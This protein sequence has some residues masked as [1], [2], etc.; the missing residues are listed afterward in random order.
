MAGKWE[1]WGPNLGISGCKASDLASG[2]CNILNLPLKKIQVKVVTVGKF[3]GV[4][5]IFNFPWRSG[6][7]WQ[8]RVK[9]WTWVY[10]CPV[11][12][13]PLH[14]A[15]NVPCAGRVNLNFSTSALASDSSS[16]WPLFCKLNMFL[17]IWHTDGTQST[18]V[19][20]RNEWVNECMNQRTN[21]MNETVWYYPGILIWLLFR[22]VSLLMTR[23]MY[24]KKHFGIQKE[25][26]L[27][28]AL[29][30][31][32][33]NLG[34]TASSIQTSASHLSAH[35]HN[36]VQNCCGTQA[37]RDTDPRRR[38]HHTGHRSRRYLL[39]LSWWR[40]CRGSSWP[41]IWTSLHPA[42]IVCAKAWVPFP[43]GHSG[44]STMKAFVWKAKQGQE[45][46]DLVVTQVLLWPTP[47][48]GSLNW[49]GISCNFT[50]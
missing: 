23:P 20:C 11:P 6:H 45:N 22:P 27:H 28:P 5:L 41:A 26:G 12:L 25:L 30:L 32:F 8:V 21:W 18:F 48:S 33:V 50:I 39:K 3:G 16:S 31:S 19:A 34:H 17:F 42:V 43:E 29:P 9:V 40:R 44:D 36:Q 13:G 2:K 7:T 1:S 49:I 24:S 47:C 10:L 35:F 15:V 14:P 38:E 46:V 37:F 4:W